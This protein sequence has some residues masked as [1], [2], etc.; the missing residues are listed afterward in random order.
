MPRPCFKCGHRVNS[1]R[2]LYI[3]TPGR[4]QIVGYLHIRCWTPTPKKEA[5]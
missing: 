3:V 1:V 4:R 5:N 2:C